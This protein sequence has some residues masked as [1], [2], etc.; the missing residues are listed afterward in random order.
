MAAGA[1]ARPPGSAGQF[2]SSFP[3]PQPA[4]GQ[5]PGSSPGPGQPLTPS[6]AAAGRGGATPTT[7][8]TCDFVPLPSPSSPYPAVGSPASLAAGPLPGRSTPAARTPRVTPWLMPCRLSGLLWPAV[9]AVL[10]LPH[11]LLGHGGHQ[12]AHLLGQPLLRSSRAEP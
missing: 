11:L 1:E 5:L 4:A 6:R 10:N 12:L 7:Q 3:G 2:P 9:A 8:W